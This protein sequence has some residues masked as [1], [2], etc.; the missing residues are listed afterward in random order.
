[1]RA[2]HH[3][4]RNSCKAVAVD[5]NTVKLCTDKLC[6]TVAYIFSMFILKLKVDTV[7]VHRLCS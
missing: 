5:I 7:V 6:I 4:Q 1:M 3:A 2:R